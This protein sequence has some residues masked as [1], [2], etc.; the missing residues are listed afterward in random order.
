MIDFT[1]LWLLGSSIAFLMMCHIVRYAGSPNMETWNHEDWKF[2]FVYSVLFPF[3]ILI[4]IISGMC[5]II[6]DIID[7][8]HDRIFRELTRSRTWRIR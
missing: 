2:V 4:W 8:M 3:G 5:M 1:M 6:P 7:F